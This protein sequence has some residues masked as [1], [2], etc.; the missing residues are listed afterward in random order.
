MNTIRRLYLYAVAFIS[1]MVIT[2]GLIGL[3]RSAFAGD[4][5][6]NDVTRLAG[7]LAL[8][9]VGIPVFLLHWWLAQRAANQDE[10]E[11]FSYIRAVF[12]YGAL[13]ATLIP[14]IQNLTALLNRI[15]FTLFDLSDNRMMFGS[16]QIWSDN[17]IA[18]LMN[19]LIVAYLFSI[20]R[21]DWAAEPIGAAYS[22]TRRLYRF[23]WMLYGLA[24]LV[25]GVQQTL[26]YL[27]D[28]LENAAIPSQ[29]I[30]AN[31]LTLILVGMPTWLICWRI[32]QKA[33]E[34]Q[35]EQESLLRAVILF[36]VNL[37]SMVTT[38]FAGGVL[39]NIII[40]MIFGERLTFAG[41]MGELRDP[42]SVVIPFGI[43]WA[44]FSRIRRQDLS[45]IEVNHQQPNRVQEVYEYL[46]AFLGLIAFFI[47]LQ[48]LAFFTTS[49]LVEQPIFTNIYR[50][51]LS[52]ALTV[53][54]IGLP[55]WLLNWRKVNSHIKQDGDEENHLESSL[56]RRIYL[57]LVL[58]ISVIGVMISAGVLIFEVLQAILGDPDENLLQTVLELVSLLIL[59]SLVIWYHALI[60]RSDGRLSAQIQA[61]LQA[62]FPVLVL[63]SE[64]GDFS[65]MMVAALSK[66]APTMPVAVHNIE[67]GVP[68]EDLSDA[69]AV[70][71]P[72]NIAANPG[73]AIRL[74][75]QNFSGVRFVIPT[76][77]QGWVWV[78]GNG[79][80]IQSLVRQTAEMVRKLAEGEQPEQ[81]RLI[82]P[83][84]IFG[85]IM[86][87]V[88]GLIFLLIA[89]STLIDLLT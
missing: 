48:Q 75:L 31:G 6:G 88:L 50:E 33:V 55:L 51:R 81:S 21:K 5:I 30:L 36:L 25:G 38:L 22:E 60:L 13:L 17:L 34:E 15:F 57:Y 52:V 27:F 79:G 11:R 32:L 45:A 71:L 26:L 63:V 40:Q 73:E 4:Q 28:A 9:F 10:E 2:W 29:S 77:V 39:L 83:W 43:A 86:G 14:I 1:L 69:R 62:E 76:P 47:G 67:A 37:I 65:E 85:Y 19:G 20:L 46:A 56:I 66:E 59:F 54:L 53:L 23:I 72:A 41:L 42:I 64:F 16:D 87:G 84:L 18:M 58:F 35:A 82:S 89:I 74:W 70:I 44:Y 61:K 80:K 8:I 78:S 49:L 24:M 12:L 68:D 7:A 3:A